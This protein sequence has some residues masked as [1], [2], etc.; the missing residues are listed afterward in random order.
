MEMNQKYQQLTKEKP[1]K[2]LF[3]LGAPAVL[4]SLFNELN[5]I[6]DAIF[7]GQFYGEDAVSSMA[8]IFPF[9]ILISAIAFLFSEGTGIAIGRYLG[10]K[11]VDKANDTMMSTIFM[12]LIVGTIVGVIGFFIAPY[13]LDLY[14]LTPYAREYALIYIQIC[15]LG[16][17]VIM[18]SVILSKIVYTEGHS[19]MILHVAVMQLIM[20]TSINYFFIGVLGIGIK[21]IAIATLLSMFIQCWILYRFINSDKLMMKIRFKH[22]KLSKGYLRE[23]LP[24]GLPTFITM[25]LLSFTLGIESK[26]ISEFGSSALSVQTITGYLFSATSSVS[27]GIMGAALVL[28]SYSVGANNQE[29]FKKV[30]KISIITVFTSALLMNIPLI[31]ASGTVAKLFTDSIDLIRMI[32]TPALIYGVTAAFIFSTNV[33]L[34]AMQPIGMENLSTAIFTIQ[35]V[36]LF[37]PLLF[38]LKPLGFDFAISAQPTSEVIGGVMTLLLIPL[39][40]CRVKKHFESKKVLT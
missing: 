15:S 4:T 21:G 18:L 31:F 37:V 38:I 32:K 33:Y 30:L 1:L 3:A 9:F 34:Y 8:I 24:L 17:P 12:T 36:L 14:Q 16:M 2:V 22:L 13:L 19:S 11:N 7:M 27:S 25:L 29:R 6:I 5:G 35:Q 40:N 10:A 20:N 39:F 23:V 28:M 26:V